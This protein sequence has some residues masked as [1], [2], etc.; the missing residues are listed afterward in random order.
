M[1]TEK[2]IL[3]F[4]TENNVKFVRL[5]FCDIYGA[6]KNISIIADELSDAFRKGF[7]FYP[8]NVKGFEF[9]DEPVLYLYP[10]ASTI[11]LLPWRPK[12]SSVI[13]MFCT[14][15]DGNGRIF[16]GD[17]RQILGNALDKAREMGFLCKI[18][19]D[20]EFYLF[21]TDE[22]G[23]PTTIPQDK[24]EYLDVAPLD[25][26]ENIRR[27]ICLTLEEMGITPYSSHHENGPGQ[28]EIDF[29]HSEGMTAADNFINFKLVVKAIAE[30]NGLYASFMPKPIDNVNCS[31]LHMDVKLKSTE[32][33]SI[34][35]ERKY[36]AA[37]IY[38]RL[39][40]ITAFLNP[41]INSYER[42]GG[43]NVPQYMSWSR[44][45]LLSIIRI[46]EED[47]EYKRIKLRSA[48]PTCNPYLTFSLIINAGLEGIKNKE[49]LPSES[50][51]NRDCSANSEA[52]PKTLDEALLL[53]ERSDFVK[54]YIPQEL[55]D[56]Y[57][58]TRRKLC[59][60]YESAAD[61][62]EYIHKLYFYC[63]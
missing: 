48:D 40:E 24:A 63:V 54:K 17:T 14:I 45:N 18:G 49:L 28:N 27:D 30:R 19:T 57:I 22:K 60:Q 41:T 56:N 59:L 15:K 55:L 21:E 4:V 5:A 2:E 43:F 8:S 1:Y 51:N 50:V 6:V 62:K 7:R 13:R 46:I 25:K 9:T 11:S 16:S 52:L 58:S 10:I 44:S 36:F 38:N 33:K 3:Q 29:K 39:K 20:T 34:T 61:K 47:G 32:D 37:G 12:Q 26:G 53:A 31:G 42:L 35:A 23:Q